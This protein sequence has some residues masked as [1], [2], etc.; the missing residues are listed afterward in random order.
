VRL[1]PLPLSFLASATRL[2]DYLGRRT[3]LLHFRPTESGLRIP[4]QYRAVSVPSPGRMWLT[5][6]GKVTPSAVDLFGMR[7]SKAELLDHLAKYEWREVLFTLSIVD[8]MLE[9]E[10]QGDGAA[11]RFLFGDRAIEVASRF[12]RFVELQ[13]EH[14]SRNLPA[15]FHPRQ[16]TTCARLALT[17]A[18][19]AR[20]RSA[21]SRYELGL[22][23]LMLSEFTDAGSD[24]ATPDIWAYRMSVEGLFR[25]GKR[26]LNGLARVH[27]LFLVE[28]S[29]R[30]R[31]LSGYMVPKDRLNQLFGADALDVMAVV[32]AI[33]GH[34]NVTHGPGRRICL[35]DWWANQLNPPP[36]A[37]SAVRDFF[38]L[39]AEQLLEEHRDLDLADIKPHDL[40]WLARGPLVDFGTAAFCPFLDVLTQRMTGAFHH[41]FLNPVRT[42]RRERSDFLTFLG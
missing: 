9:Q 6:V 15:L 40:V 29:S 17:L 33:W 26:T 30:L 35:W 5:D 38:A 36:A 1:P 24:Q 23:L 12:L 18:P 41:V 16:L 8:E 27:E 7:P 2:P 31:G 10:G 32:H 21:S 28:P 37:L 22:V 13:V 20:P 34:L 14:G 25:S 11:A 3:S 42:T 39:S 19:A 4:A